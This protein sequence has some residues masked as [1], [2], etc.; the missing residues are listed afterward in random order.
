MR[1]SFVSLHHVSANNINLQEVH[2]SIR[3][4]YSSLLRIHSW[5]SHDVDV[6]T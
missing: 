2:Y 1:F 4:E 5:T 6:D 3:I